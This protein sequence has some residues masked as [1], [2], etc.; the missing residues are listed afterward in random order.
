MALNKDS[1]KLGISIL[2]QINRGARVV[3]Y[4]RYD[5]STPYVDTKKIF[6]IDEKSDGGY[7]N[8]FTNIEDM[9]DEQVKLW[10]QLKGEVPNSSFMDKLEE[11]DYPTSSRWM[12][13]K[14][15]NITSIGWF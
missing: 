3:R 7:E 1:V 5:R 12:E 15:K 10:E 13:E 14:D 2:N 11:K 4:E 9:T 6:C 8:V